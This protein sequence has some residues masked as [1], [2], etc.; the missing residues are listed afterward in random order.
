MTIPVDEDQFIKESQILINNIIQIFH[1][2]NKKYKNIIFNQSANYWNI[3]LSTKFYD[4]KNNYSR[5]PRSIFWSMKRTE[6]FSYPGHDVET[7]IKWYKEIQ[8]K[9]KKNFIKKNILQINYEKF[10]NNFDSEKL[11]KFTN[12]S[13]DDYG[14]FDKE[15]SMKNLY[16]AKNS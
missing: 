5:H 10:L 15:K 3:D 12:T 1:K 13:K 16:K 9:F 14:T 8:K 7:F 11:N 2:D 4:N 6:A